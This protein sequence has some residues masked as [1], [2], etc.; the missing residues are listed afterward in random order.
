MYEEG[1]RVQCS[2][3]LL[4][5]TAGLEN[6]YLIHETLILDNSVS[7]TKV[8]LSSK[9]GKSLCLLLVTD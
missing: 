8:P 2:C 1:G 4:T 7:R 9:D 5:I 6:N 3:Y